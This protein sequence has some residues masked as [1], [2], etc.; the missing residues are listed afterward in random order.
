[1]FGEF[2]AEAAD[3][4]RFLNMGLRWVI[5][6]PTAGP[7]LIGS[8]EAP[9]FRLRPGRL[10]MFAPAQNQRH[11]RTAVSSPGRTFAFRLP[12]F[13]KEWQL[14]IIQPSCYTA[15]VRG[16]Y[17]NGKRLRLRL[18]RGNSA[19]YKRFAKLTAREPPNSERGRLFFL[20]CVLSTSSP[21][22]FL[23]VRASPRG[24]ILTAHRLTRQSALCWRTCPN[25]EQ[26]I[27]LTRRAL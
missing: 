22:A 7:A 4:G 15:V 26:R 17:G 8:R 12:H 19:N 14:R 21:G 2:L 18:K 16:V 24:V 9:G 1:M 23:A 10:S 27:S 13:G 5:P 3:V 6:P 11:N 25:G 20:S